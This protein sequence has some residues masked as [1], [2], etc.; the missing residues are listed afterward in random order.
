MCQQ[1][2][3]QTSKH[4]HC[5]HHPYPSF[6][7]DFEITLRMLE[8]EQVFLPL[9]VRQHTSFQFKW[10]LMETLKQTELVMKV[11]TTIKQIYLM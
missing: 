1:F 3:L 2:E 7:K 9:S 5:D 8:E 4:A 11:E 10:G 6:G